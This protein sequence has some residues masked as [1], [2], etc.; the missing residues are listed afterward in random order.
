M[1]HKVSAKRHLVKTISYR[2]ISTFVG[3]LTMWYMTGS[4]KFGAAFGIAEIILKP[5]IYYFHERIWYKK[6]KFGLIEEKIH[7]PKKVQLNEDLSKLLD[8][9]LNSDVSKV[10]DNLQSKPI[11]EEPI[12]LTKETGKKVL[13]YSS[14]R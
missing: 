6:I 13:N 8:N 10:L 9:Q 7:K 11:S 1:S 3:F 5:I 4:I 14:N 2:I 12:K